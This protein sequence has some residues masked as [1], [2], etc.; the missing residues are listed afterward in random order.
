MLIAYI[1]GVSIAVHLLNLLCIPA[2]VLVVYYRKFRNTTATGSL[3]AL[4]ISAVIVALI[5]FGLVPGFIE[6]SQ[7]FE[8]FFVNTLG[9]S[10]NTGVLVYAILFVAVAVW[11]IHTL[12]RQKSAN[13][14]RISFLLTVLL[15]GIPFIGHSLLI[16]LVIVCA[17]AVWLFAAKRLPVR[18]LTLVALSILVISSAIRATRFCLSALTPIRR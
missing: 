10:F 11:S 15:S 5:L 13:C 12:Y 3:I 17:L 7:Y 4:A 16:P 1:I 2:I 14:I 6:V 18:V 8:L 9:W